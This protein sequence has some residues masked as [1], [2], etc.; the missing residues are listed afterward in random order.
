MVESGC[1]WARWRRL[2]SPV[3]ECSLIGP[4]RGGALP[5]C[6]ETYLARADAARAL[7]LTRTSTPF[8]IAVRF[9][10]GLDDAYR[11]AFAAAADRW[12][13]VVVGELPGVLAGGEY[14]DDLLV[15]VQ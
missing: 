5:T 15:L 8:T 3:S 13:R 10:G 6:H 4:V 9:L 14:I 1:I 12:V 11:A 7:Q 2:P